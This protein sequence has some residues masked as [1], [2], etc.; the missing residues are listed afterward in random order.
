MSVAIQVNDLSKVYRLGEIGTGTI[1]Q[2][3]HRWFTTLMG[4]EDPFLKIGESNDRT[5]KGASNVVYS[6]REIN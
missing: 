4:R 3:I 2:D 6:L 5:I 1:S